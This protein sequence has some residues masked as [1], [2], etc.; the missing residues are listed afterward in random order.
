[1]ITTPIM[2]LFMSRFCPYNKSTLSALTFLII[3]VLNYLMLGYGYAGELN[4]ISKKLDYI[5]RICVFYHVIWF[6][7]FQVF[8]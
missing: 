3:L 2:L 6:C 7:I 1:M 4:L 8:I 5:I